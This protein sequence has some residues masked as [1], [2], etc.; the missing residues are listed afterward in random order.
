M[1]AQQKAKGSSTDVVP[2]PSDDTPNW[3]SLVLGGSFPKV[4]RIFVERYT[5]PKSRM[6]GAKMLRPH[7]PAPDRP[8]ETLMGWLGTA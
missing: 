3:A 6:P 4:L 8:R 7:V 1:M 5:P 2:C